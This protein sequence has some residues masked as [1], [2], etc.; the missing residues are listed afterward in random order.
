MWKI[1]ETTGIKEPFMNILDAGTT[2][3]AKANGEGLSKEDHHRLH[4]L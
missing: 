2:A 4:C 3:T 1:E